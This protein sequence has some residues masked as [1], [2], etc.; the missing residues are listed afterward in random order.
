MSDQ[1]IDI[2]V[3]VL[4]APG[5]DEAH[6]RCYS[7]IEASDIGQRYTVCEHPPGVTAREHWQ[8]TL[9]RAAAARSE[10]V[11]VLEDD[12]L[13]NRHILDNCRSWKW[14]TAHHFGAGW[15]YRPGG[16]CGDRDEW[17]TKGIDWYGTVGVL[18]RTEL[19]GRFVEEACAWM[20]EHDSNAWDCAIARAVLCGGY[21]LRVHYPSLVEHM[22]D[23]PSKV[24][25]ETNPEHDYYFRSSRGT[26]KVDWKRPA[27][28]EHGRW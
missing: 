27:G 28:H 11:L 9:E 25:H 14:P 10:L 8:R 3:V 15:L 21:G 2:D 18:Y 6:R 23:V 20:A 22:I 12:C 17:Y 7:S 26:F 16:F 1:G 13:V 24:G 19:L 5:R 4:A